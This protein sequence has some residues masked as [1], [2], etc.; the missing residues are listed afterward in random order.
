MSERKGNAKRD[1]EQPDDFKSKKS[2]RAKQ[3]CKTAKQLFSPY[4]HE[5]FSLLHEMREESEN[6]RVIVS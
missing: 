6:R 1:V 4:R 3:I 2:K 5:F